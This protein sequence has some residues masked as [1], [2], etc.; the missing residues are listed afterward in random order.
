MFATVLDI[1]VA[2]RPFLGACRR[3][4]CLDCDGIHGFSV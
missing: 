1:D 4:D 3:S 2:G